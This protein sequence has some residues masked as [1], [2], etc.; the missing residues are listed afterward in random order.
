MPVGVGGGG[1][2][3][4]GRPLEIMAHLKT[5]I[6]QVKAETNCLAHAL[7][8]T[9]AGVDNDPNCKAYRDSRKRKILPAVRQLLE[10]TGINLD[11][12]GG[13]P[14]LARF[15]EHFSDYKIVV[16]TGLY[17]DSIMFEGGGQ[18]NQYSQKRLDRL[19][20]DVTRHHVITY[21]TSYSQ[22][23]RLYSV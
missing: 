19:Y 5:S 4:K 13:I 1:I 16:Y 15:R 6:V 17:C 23:L 18:Q 12:G 9:N 3:N 20:D 11:N 22:T 21:L 10:E 14:E 7:M 2:K 8:I